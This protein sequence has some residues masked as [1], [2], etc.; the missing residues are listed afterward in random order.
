MKKDEAIT[1]IKE[2]LETPDDISILSLVTKEGVQL[3]VQNVTT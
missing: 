2:M 1:K 3:V